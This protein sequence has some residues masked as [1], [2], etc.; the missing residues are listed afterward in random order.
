MQMYYMV[1]V[2]IS[3]LVWLFTPI[4]Q[5]KTRY[6]WFFL[7]LALADPFSLVVGRS[8]HLVLAQLYVPTTILCFFAVIDYKRISVYNSLFYLIIVVLGYFSFIQFWEYSLLYITVMLFLVLILFA[9]QSFQFVIEKGSINVFHVVLV[10]YQ[11]MNVLKFF[12]LIQYFSTGLW[13]YYISSVLQIF[14]GIFFALYRED[15][16]KLLIKIAETKQFAD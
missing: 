9:K 8:F 16:P 11:A 2:F 1:L 14:I 13:F 7:T 4:R 15:N 12:Y 10:F 6:F 5:F 3:C